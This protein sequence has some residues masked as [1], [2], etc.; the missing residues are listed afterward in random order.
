MGS[1]VRVCRGRRSRQVSCAAASWLVGGALLIFAGG[2]DADG[3]RQAGSVRLSSGTPASL[4]ALAE[5]AHYVN[6]S[7]TAGKP[8]PVTRIVV[9]YPDGFRIDTSVPARCT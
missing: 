2:A 6:P 9:R 7:D 1:G 5:S 4:T 8:S 3:M